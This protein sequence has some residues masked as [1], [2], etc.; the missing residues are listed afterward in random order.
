MR[1][2]TRD[3]LFYDMLGV[4]GERG[5][6]DA[7]E[8]ISVDERTQFGGGCNTCAYEYQVLDVRYR[9]VRGGYKTVVIDGSLGDLISSLLGS[10]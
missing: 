10:R 1:E 5:Y 3:A 4:L 8:V 9:T 2:S 6:D 7:E